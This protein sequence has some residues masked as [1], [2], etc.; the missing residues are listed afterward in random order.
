MTFPF[1]LGYC[2]LLSFLLQLAQRIVTQLRLVCMINRH[3]GSMPCGRKRDG[4]DWEF[5]GILVGVRILDRI[6]TLNYL[7]I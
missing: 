3:V 1:T 4:S 5:K 7:T 2:F 6:V